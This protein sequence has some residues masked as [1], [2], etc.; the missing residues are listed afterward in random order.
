MFM[1]LTKKCM[2]A[3]RMLNL[4]KILHTVSTAE[5]KGVKRRTSGMSGEPTTLL[6]KLGINSPLVEISTQWE[7]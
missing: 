2:H 5:G 3:L 6:R 4:C 1:Q 7:S